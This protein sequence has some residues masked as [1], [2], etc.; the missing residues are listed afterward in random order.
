[1][2]SVP[3]VIPASY[4]FQIASFTQAFRRSSAMSLDY[5]EPSVDEVINCLDFIWLT[6]AS[7]AKT[8]EPTGIK[9]FYESLTGKTLEPIFGGLGFTCLDDFLSSELLAD[10]M[11]TVYEK[12]KWDDFAKKKY[13]AKSFEDCKHITKM[14]TEKEIA[15]QNRESMRKQNRAAKF[16][17]EEFQL[18]SLEFRETLIR[19]VHI[20]ERENE[21]TGNSEVSW[22]SI[23]TAWENRFNEKLNRARLR[24]AFPSGS[25]QEII[26]RSMRDEFHFRQGES[27]MFWVR[28][29]KPMD[30]IIKG[31]NEVKAIKL[32]T[33]E[34]IVKAPTFR[35]DRCQFIDFDRDRKNMSLKPEGAIET[36]SAAPKPADAP[37]P[38]MKAQVPPPTRFSNYN[39]SKSA[40]R[41]T[42]SNDTPAARPPYAREYT[43][44]PPPFK[45]NSAIKPS[46][47]QPPMPRT[48]SQPRRNFDQNRP[49]AGKPPSRNSQRP[50]N[51][52]SNRPNHRGGPG[53]SSM[54]TILDAADK[55]IAEKAKESW[56]FGSLRKDISRSMESV[57][58]N[59]PKI[60]NFEPVKP[61]LE[62]RISAR[63][64]PS[65]FVKRLNRSF[66]DG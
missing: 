34:E 46:A 59:P 8:Q 60:D 43:S 55:Q 28:L 1:M 36:V 64:A 49:D 53:A 33:T 16:A 9:S 6:V 63:D 5:P 50:P 19:L 31:Y 25:P 57:L 30:E 29:K 44:K 20:L 13:I 22:Q 21:H 40:V 58:G 47:P 45:N 51:R 4:H 2:R 3:Y 42:F 18:K 62:T 15:E 37:V 23:Q 52:R 41:V 48:H 61:R 17:T 32:Q 54:N 38:L 14:M 11:S 10:L 12:T 65:H 26:Q 24:D 56:T 66:L 39:R 27:G 7:T 35:N